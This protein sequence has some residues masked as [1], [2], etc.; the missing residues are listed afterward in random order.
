MVRVRSSDNLRFKQ[1][2]HLKCTISRGGSDLR[3]SFIFTVHNIIYWDSNNLK[4]DWYLFIFVPFTFRLSSEIIKFIARGCHM[5]RIWPI[6]VAFLLSVATVG[7]IVKCSVMLVIW[8]AAFLRYYST[9][10]LSCYV[11]PRDPS[12]LVVRPT[13][14]QR[15]RELSGQYET[16][17]E[18][19]KSLH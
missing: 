13:V 12:V 9:A 1:I 14:Q 7:P 11:H 19:F 6:S 4:P 5:G 2:W 17:Y 10:T 18:N 15:G 16:I 3:G 8:C